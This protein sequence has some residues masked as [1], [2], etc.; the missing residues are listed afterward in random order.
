MQPFVWGK[1]VEKKTAESSSY[2]QD[3]NEGSKRLKLLDEINRVRKRRDEREKELEEMDRLRSEE[4]RLREAAL[5]GDWQQKEE[6]FL[7]EQTRVRSKIRLSDRREQP[8]D[9]LAKNILLIESAMSTEPGKDAALDLDMNKLEVELRDPV[10]L[11]ESLDAAMVE[12]LV[13]EID[14]YCQLAKKSGDGYEKFWES[15]R[16][17]VLQK[18]N[19]NRKTSSS[20]IHRSFQNDVEKLLANKSERELDV[21]ESDIKK[22]VADGAYPDVSYWEDISREIGMHRARTYV[23]KVHQ[24]LLHKQLEILS[25]LRDEIQASGVSVSEGTELVSAASE[26]SQERMGSAEEALL[27][28]AESSMADDESEEKM[29]S[30]DEVSLPGATYWWQD[31]HRPRKPRYFNRI[32]TGWEWNKYNST[33]YDRDNPPPKMIQ[34]YKFALF[35]PDLIDK[36]V[37]PQYFIE[38]CT[39]KEFV[40]LRFHAGPPYEDVAFKVLNKQWDTHRKSGFKCVFDRGVLQLHFNFMRQWYR[41]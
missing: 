37:A 21:L 34:G 29:R 3:D 38:P 32:R 15:M 5:Y 28:Q 18:R 7:L 4:Q 31:Q 27:R 22:G 1:K 24:D 36:T 41:R 6:E 20:H 33:H 35:Y 2:T 16:T 23:M 25:R 26:H 40:V 11:V 30:Q 12:Q 39:D 14:A 8:I 19:S 10:S 9:T 13:S 17:I